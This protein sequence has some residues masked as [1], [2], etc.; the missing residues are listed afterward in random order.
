MGWQE[1]LLTI[2][3][4][5]LS[6]SYFSK[7]S[8]MVSDKLF[9]GF[10]TVYAATGNDADISNPKTFTNHVGQRDKLVLHVHCRFSHTILSN[11]VVLEDI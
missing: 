5:D 9:S 1:S 8:L 3:L 4:F 11:D 6:H 10:G 7:D 2:S